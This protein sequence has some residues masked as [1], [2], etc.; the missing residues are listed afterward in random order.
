MTSSPDPRHLEIALQHAHA[1]QH[2]KDL[3]AR[4]DSALEALIDFPPSP[5]STPQAP[6]KSDLA[7]LSVLLRLF[8][9]SDF[10]SLIEE[11]R[12]AEKC[13]YVLCPLPPSKSKRQSTY[14]LL[15]SQ[16]GGP[17]KAVPRALVES[18]CSQ[19]CA[20]R[21]AFLKMH[22]MKE[23]AWLRKDDGVPDLVILTGSG[24]MPT[25][26]PLPNVEQPPATTASNAI[27]S[28]NQTT[29]ITPTVVERYP[30]TAN[31][32]PTSIKYDHNAVEG[33]ST[34]LASIQ[35]ESS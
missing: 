18:W 26:T 4:I 19:D 27:G 33:Y 7:E 32:P 17:L 13:G 3:Q 14:R 35:K 11:R 10:D 9:P 15:H 23:P 6:A 30:S 24:D 5:D 20:R 25:E 29:T 1:L 31:A 8:C 21:A 12:C 28:T 22:L 34:K 2:R 16:K